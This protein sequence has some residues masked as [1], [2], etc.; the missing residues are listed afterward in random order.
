MKKVCIIIPIYHIEPTRQEIVSIQTTMEKL[1][2]HDVFFIAPANVDVAYYRDKFPN[3]QIR[4]YTKWTN[5]IDSYSRLL[6]SPAFYKEYKEYEYM[7]IVQTDALVLGTDMQ[8]QKFL[9]LGYDYYGAAWEGYASVNGREIPKFRLP[10]WQKNAWIYR[11][12]RV[13]RCMVGNGGFSLRKVDSCLKLLTKYWFAA[14]CWHENEDLFFSYYAI[15]EEFKGAPFEVAIT[16]AREENLKDALQSGTIP[17]GVHAWEKDYPE[18][19]DYLK[20]R[21]MI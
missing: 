17:F 19:F 1:G 15:G 5:D 11:L 14:L 8:L 6:I 10:K 16:F 3:V 20:T 21:G 18:L 7:L 12:A 2:T 4:K 9:D 13:R